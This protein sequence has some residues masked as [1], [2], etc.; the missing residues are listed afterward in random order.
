MPRRHAGPGRAGCLQNAI[1]L[2]SGAARL[3]GG[4]KREQ[5]L[6]PSQQE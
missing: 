2:C 3:D 5:N 4:S 6:V 1:S